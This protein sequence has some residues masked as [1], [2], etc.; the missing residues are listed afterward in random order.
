MNGQDELSTIIW[1]INA[2]KYTM[3][4]M[5]VEGNFDL[6]QGNIKELT[7]LRD[8]LVNQSDV[9]ACILRDFKRMNKY[10]DVLMEYRAQIKAFIDK[11]NEDS[12]YGIT[13]A[14]TNK[15][16]KYYSM[17]SMRLQGIESEISSLT[18][19]KIN[20]NFLFQPKGTRKLQKLLGR[21]SFEGPSSTSVTGITSSYSMSSTAPLNASPS[22]S[23][24]DGGSRS[25][26]NGTTA[27]IQQH[28]LVSS[29]Y[30]SGSASPLKV[31][32]QSLFATNLSESGS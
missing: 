16:F 14:T 8:R 24:Y 9:I 12:I 22:R 20:M 31:L 6:E 11:K 26:E 5:R 15:F 17:L 18:Q 3:K 32:M 1:L 21:N 19:S 23:Q 2:I 4:R 29:S 10:K 13:H 27:N 30:A 7:A 25:S 28:N